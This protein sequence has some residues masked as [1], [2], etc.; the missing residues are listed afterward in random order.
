MK[1]NHVNGLIAVVMLFASAALVAEQPKT[2]TLK[3]G[4]VIR[5]AL[6]APVTSENAKVNDIVP[7]KALDDVTVDGVVVIAKDA[8]GTAHVSSVEKKGKWGKAGGIEVT[9]DF[10][11]AVDGNNVGLTHAVVTQGG[12]GMSTGAMM[13]GLS[14]AFKKGKQAAI[15]ANDAINGYVDADCAI[16]VSDAP[17]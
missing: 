3:K 11:K 13:M 16:A 2:V 5:V 6:A 12:G 15:P 8:T 10:V 1:R 14:G 4:T 9:V 7:V 17:R